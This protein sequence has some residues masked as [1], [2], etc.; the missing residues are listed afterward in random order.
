MWI[1]ADK[2]SFEVICAFKRCTLTYGGVRTDMS[3]LCSVLISVF[4]PSVEGDVVAKVQKSYSLHEL[5]EICITANKL[6]CLN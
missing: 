5:M 1:N 3:P 6:N 4:K 2:R